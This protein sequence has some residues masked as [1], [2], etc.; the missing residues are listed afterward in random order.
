MTGTLYQDNGTMHINGG[1]LNVSGNYYM[2][3][4]DSIYVTGREV[5]FPAYS[6]L[7]MECSEDEVLV[8]N[9][10]VIASCSNS[11]RFSDGVMYVSG[12]FTQSGS[13]NSFVAS[14]SHKVVLSGSASQ[15]VQF[16]NSNSTFNVLQLKMPLERY[17][18]S[19]KPCWNTL[20]QPEVTVLCLPTALRMIED[21]AFMNNKGLTIVELQ[22][23]NL[24]AIG[25][26]AF[27]GCTN[28]QQITIPVSVESIADDAFD[29]CDKLLI[30][31][32]SGSYAQ[33]YANAHDITWKEY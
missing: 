20:I 13:S 26:G 21:E 12:D 29:G 7:I 3:G 33:Q 10:F 4:A 27:K 23:E 22:G 1:K 6:S 32:K 19:T 30:V 17:D 16:D 9:D 8:G 14:N 31:C 11:N 18:F 2:A 28:L 25:S 24:I 15:T 5:Y